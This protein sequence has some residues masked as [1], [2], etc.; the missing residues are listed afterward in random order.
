[1]DAS[2]KDIANRAEDASESVT[3]IDIN[4]KECVDVSESAYKLNINLSDELQQA[5]LVMQKVLQGS[6]S[7][8]SILDVITKI[9][10]QTNLL[11]LNA[12]IE[13]ARA[14][15][16]GRGFAVVADEVRKLAHSTKDS[17]VAVKSVIEE[18]QRDIALAGKQVQLCNDN[19]SE[20]VQSFNTI[21]NQIT[22]VNESVSVLAQL[23]NGMSVS[24]TQQ[25][26]VCNNLTQDMEAILSAAEATLTATSD[27]KEISNRL[28]SIAK[29]QAIVIE[30]FKH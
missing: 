7:I 4:I 22:R 24:T 26:N 30:V 14:G 16:S 19:M 1:M 18:L 13:A 20:N 6:H 27:V 11:A 15:E 2:V 10:E 9:T 28:I 21:Q 29:E 23:N 8:Y 5:K 12:A 3:N 25:S 17:T